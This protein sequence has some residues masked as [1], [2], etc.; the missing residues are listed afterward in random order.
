MKKET[1]AIHTWLLYHVVAP[2]VPQCA[3]VSM[4]LWLGIHMASVLGSICLVPI[5][6]LVGHP[7]FLTAPPSRSL[8]CSLPWLSL[9]EEF[10]SW[11][12]ALLCIKCLGLLAFF[13]SLDSSCCDSV[14]LAF[15]MPTKWHY[16][17][18]AVLCCK[19]PFLLPQCCEQC[20]FEIVLS[21]L[22]L[23]L[24]LSVPPLSATSHFHTACFLHLSPLNLASSYINTAKIR[25]N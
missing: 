18:D 2:S 19:A 23:I 6:F 20:F 15:C 22:K 8:H 1:K 21:S 24:A 3:P 4:M 7:I 16:R 10:H 9:A 11:N 17:N 25:K 5:A 13:E 14:S 12:L